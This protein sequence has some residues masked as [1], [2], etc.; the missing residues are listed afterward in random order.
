MRFTE[1]HNGAPLGKGLRLGIT[2][3]YLFLLGSSSLSGFATGL[4]L[5]FKA[6]SLSWPE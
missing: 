4:K 5:E 2:G 6:F 1:R 3:G